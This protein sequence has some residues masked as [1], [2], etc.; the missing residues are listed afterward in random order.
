[1]DAETARLLAYSNGTYSTSDWGCR[2]D[3][4]GISPKMFPAPDFLRMYTDWQKALV[5]ASDACV[6]QNGVCWVLQPNQQSPRYGQEAAGG[7][8]GCR[9]PGP[10][11]FAGLRGTEAPWTPVAA[12]A[13]EGVTLL[14]SDAVPPIWQK[15]PHIEPPNRLVSAPS[16]VLYR[17]AVRAA[18]VISVR[19]GRP[20]V[21]N[22]VRDGKVVPVTYVDPGGLVRTHPK[23]RGWGT[24]VYSM[25]PL[26]VRQTYAASRGASLLPWGM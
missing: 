13:P 2:G 14:R 23:A 9:G 1:M 24:D 5:E 12:V 8:P 21:V 26:E 7:C 19:L 3:V 20:Q 16:S 11:G 17:A 15:N 18:Q 22:G 10:T 4:I 6:L 25:D